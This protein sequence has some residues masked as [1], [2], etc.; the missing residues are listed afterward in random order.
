MPQNPTKVDW[1]GGRGGHKRLGFSGVALSGWAR[2][3]SK[4]GHSGS[5]RRPQHLRRAVGNGAR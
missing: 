3:G 1:G 4:R 2:C 5:D